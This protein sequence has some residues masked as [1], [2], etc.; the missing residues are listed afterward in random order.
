MASKAIQV[1][2]GIHAKLKVLSEKR[3]DEGRHDYS[4]SAIVAELVLA[5]HKKEFK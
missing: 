2:S 4:M 1:N 3:Q 5:L